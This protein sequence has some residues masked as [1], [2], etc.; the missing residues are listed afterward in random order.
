MIIDRQ[1][2]K[3]RGRE[4]EGWRETQREREKERER[5]REKRRNGYLQIVIDIYREIDNCRQ[6]YIYREKKK[7]RQRENK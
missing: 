1:I 6:I 7:I 4:P 3:E 2:Q 5:V